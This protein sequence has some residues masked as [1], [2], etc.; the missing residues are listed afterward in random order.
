[1]K[2][3]ICMQDCTWGNRMI[4]AGDP[5]TVPDH[6]RLP[7]HFFLPGQQGG[8]ELP[9]R[10]GDVF[11]LGDGPSLDEDL[12]VTS[13]FSGFS[14]MAI[15]RAAFRWQHALDFWVS[16]HS[17]LFLEWLRIRRALGMDCEGVT[18]IAQVPRWSPPT[19]QV[20]PPG[21]G[22]SALLAIHA[23]VLMGFDRIILAG[24]G[25]TGQYERFRR[26][27]AEYGLRESMKGRIKGLSGWARGTFG[28]PQELEEFD[29]G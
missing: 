28:L 16:A 8:G 5:I 29:L 2:L 6:A 4:K 3:A 14:V 12:I 11:I 13:L 23:A 21:K 26:A 27:I 15:N 19:I 20:T 1:M 17:D 10:S 7:R 25:L 9:Q 18:F 24:V 22:G